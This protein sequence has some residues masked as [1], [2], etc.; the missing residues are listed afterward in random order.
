[1]A[2]ILV[3][4]SDRF[5]ADVL[6]CTLGLDAHE[7]SVCTSAREGVRQGQTDPPD[8]VVA[9]WRLKGDMHGGEV[10]RRICESTPGVK[11]IVIAGTQDCASEASE[12]G[13][14]VEAIIAK[15][16]HRNEI[17][18]AVHRVLV[19]ESAYALADSPSFS[20]FSEKRGSYQLL[21]SR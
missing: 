4:E 7:V 10:C 3:V 2:R 17:L 5:F 8:V 15:P 6:A 12:Y 16:F 9:A 19:G 13:N 21:N 11:A 20:P 14:C 1:M 18:D